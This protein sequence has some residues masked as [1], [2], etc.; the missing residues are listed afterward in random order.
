MTL[1]NIGF[2][3]GLSTVIIAIAALKQGRPRYVPGRTASAQAEKARKAA[4]NIRPERQR[5]LSG[6]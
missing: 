2:L 4:E 3:A 6:W 5:Y 1:G